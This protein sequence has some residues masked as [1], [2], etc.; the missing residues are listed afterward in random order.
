[1]VYTSNE[2][3]NWPWRCHKGWKGNKTEWYQRSKWR[4]FEVEWEQSTD[5]GMQCF[6]AKSRSNLSF[7]AFKFHLLHICSLSLTK[8]RGSQ[9]T[10]GRPFLHIFLF[11][12]HASWS[13]RE[14]KALKRWD[15]QIPSR[16]FTTALNTSWTLRP[17]LHWLY[18]LQKQEITLTFSF[19]WLW[20]SML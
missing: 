9:S 18:W 13:S 3:S 14:W 6:R 15:D 5:S 12:C 1:M 2:Q 7:D 19:I 10:M 4:G 20:S 17:K 11:N 16:P 8:L